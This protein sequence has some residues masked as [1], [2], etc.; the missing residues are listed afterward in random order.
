MTEFDPAAGLDRLRE[1]FAREPNGPPAGWE[2]VSAFEARHG[3]VLPEPFRSFA[4]TVTSGGPGCGPGGRPLTTLPAELPGDPARPFPLTGA[5][6]WA[7]RADPPEGVDPEEVFDGVLPLDAEAGAAT[8]Y[9][10]VSGTHRGHVWQL[11]EEGA[12]PFGREFGS[13]SGASGF[14]GWVEHW[15]GPRNTD[16]FAGWWDVAP[17]GAG[18]AGTDPGRQ[19]V[20]AVRRTDAAGAARREV[21]KA[22][23]TGQAT[24]ASVLDRAATDPVIGKAEVGHLLSALP[25]YRRSD[26]QVVL[27]RAG[28]AEQQ[29]AWSL[30]GARRRALLDAVDSH[31][32]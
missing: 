18:E 32:R 13:T 16:G 7:V 10:V 21:W 5:W 4:A 29:R 17:A 11:A 14:L 19:R 31:V 12:T 25:G 3:V 23:A 8:W 20:G 30:T 2:A 15:K 24:I 1:L 28:V 9:L 22:I 6:P 27:L 26:V